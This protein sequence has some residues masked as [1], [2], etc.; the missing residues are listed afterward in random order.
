MSNDAV[1]ARIAKRSHT[2]L[3]RMGRKLIFS[4]VFLLLLFH[5]IST[6]NNFTINV[7]KLK[8]ILKIVF[9]TLCFRFII[10]IFYAVSVPP[11]HLICSSLFCKS[12]KERILGEVPCRRMLAITSSGYFDFSQV[13]ASYFVW[14]LFVA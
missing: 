14:I 11:V 3:L 1:Y 8:I 5:F 13:I 9:F 7:S 2:F 12:S 4:L 6:N 10:F